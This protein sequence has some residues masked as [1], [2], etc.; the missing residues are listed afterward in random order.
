MSGVF[1]YHDVRQVD[2][3]VSWGMAEPTGVVC[4]LNRHWF[5]SDVL[6]LWISIFVMVDTHEWRECTGE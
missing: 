5:S 4:K 3:F 2:S 6:I 1:C